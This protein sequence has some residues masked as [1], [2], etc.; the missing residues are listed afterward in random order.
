MATDVRRLR[1]GELIVEIQAM[2]RMARERRAMCRELCGV[3]WFCPECHG[4]LPLKRRLLSAKC[5]RGWWLM[6]PSSRRARLR[7]PC[8]PGTRRSPN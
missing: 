1:G 6:I 7:A 3:S 4:L 8:C 5:P 2:D